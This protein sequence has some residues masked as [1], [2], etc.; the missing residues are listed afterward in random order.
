GANASIGGMLANNA[1]GIRTVKY[2][3]TRDNVL[4]LE[5]VLANGDII[6]TGSRSIKQSAGYD[7][8]HLFVGSEGTLGV[9]TEATL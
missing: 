9:I 6:R 2:G 5:V 7:L 4:A 8:T 1:A 3:A